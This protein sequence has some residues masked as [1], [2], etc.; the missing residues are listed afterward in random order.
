MTG[1]EMMH[2]GPARVDELYPPQAGGECS[3]LRT[4]MVV[5]RPDRAGAPVELARALKV[6]ER[7][8]LARRKETLDAWLS[9]S[10][11]SRAAASLSRMLSGMRGEAVGEED[12]EVISAQYAFALRDLPFW[13]IERACQRFASGLVRPQ[14]IGAKSL[15]VGFRPSTA[16]VAT[17]ARA[18]SEP[19]ERERDELDR[20][21]RGVVAGARPI[22]R[23]RGSG[24]SV[25]AH[26]AGADE[27]EVERRRRRTE[28]IKARQ[29]EVERRTN[30]ARAEEYRR[31]GL[32][33]PEPRGGLITSL[34]MMLKMGHTIEEIGDEKVLLGPSE[35]R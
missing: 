34:P 29:P 8:M 24:A 16:Q 5:F 4:T 6:E 21:L 11:P 32:R 33:P 1:R 22:T 27:A 25:D 19:L 35:P 23:S 26:L 3:A 20:I 14:E 10:S 17:V 30:A 12:A 13:A 18:L 31:A 28:E 9:P 15:D 7:S 2:T